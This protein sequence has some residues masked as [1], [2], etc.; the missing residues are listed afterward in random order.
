MTHENTLL[1]K[2]CLQLHKVNIDWNHFKWR[3]KISFYLFLLK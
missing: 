3:F 2:R 1:I